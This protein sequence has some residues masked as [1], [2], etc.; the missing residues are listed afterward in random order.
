MD[1]LFCTHE[2]LKNVA[3]HT[4]IKMSEAVIDMWADVYAANPMIALLGISFEMFLI[5]PH[6]F[7]PTAN[8]TAII[9]LTDEMLAR[10]PLLPKQRAVQERLDAADAG[11]LSFEL[12]PSIT[13]TGECNVEQA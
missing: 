11:Q 9:P 6:K 7:L 1:Y 13:N 4:P 3:A 2:R 10:L 5:Q 8:F 12:D